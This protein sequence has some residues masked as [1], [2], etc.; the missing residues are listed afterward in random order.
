MRNGV[1][2]SISRRTVVE[3][4]LERLGCGGTASVANP[5]QPRGQVAGRRVAAPDLVDE[6]I[7]GLTP[8]HPP[9]IVAPGASRKSAM[10]DSD[11]ATVFRPVTARGMVP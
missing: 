10:L 9:A 5:I 6:G 2:A 11:C 3:P 4:A 7:A 8:E 1:S